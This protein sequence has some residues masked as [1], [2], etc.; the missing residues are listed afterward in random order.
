MCAVCHQHRSAGMMAPM[1]S[2]L[3]SLKDVMK[4][5]WRDVIIDCQGPFT[6]SE[7][8]NHYVVSYH[9][10]FLGVCKVQPF[11]RLTKQEF[12]RAMVTCV[13]RSRRIPDIVRTDRG[14]EMTSAVMEEFCVLCNVKQ[15][16][17][18]AFTPRHQG[19]GERKHQEVM[20][21]WLILIHL[22]LIHI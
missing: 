4:L 13:M 15:Y 5:L 12:L 6:K 1:R 18:A 21:Q 11:P 19:P 9:C 14:P 3:G 8:G 16:L 20:K 7:Q 2:T 22:S 10:T 17:G